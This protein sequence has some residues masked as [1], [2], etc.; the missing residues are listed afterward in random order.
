MPPKCD[1]CNAPAY[2]GEIKIE[3]KE[4]H[5]TYKLCGYCLPIVRDKIAGY[6]QALVTNI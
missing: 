6:I 4:L 5:I 3:S 2:E 1:R